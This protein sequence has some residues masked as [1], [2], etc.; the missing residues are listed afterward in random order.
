MGNREKEKSR[1]V[2]MKIAFFAGGYVLIIGL[3]LFIWHRL[4]KELKR[5]EISVNNRIA[6]AANN[7][8][9]QVKTKPE[10]DQKMEGKGSVYNPSKDIDRM[11]SGKH[12]DF[13]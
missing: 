4:Q 13:Y 2:L 9:N 6:E 8:I 5:V 1:V 3:S 7:A 12:E 11:L 10:I